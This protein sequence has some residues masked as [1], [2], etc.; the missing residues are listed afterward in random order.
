MVSTQIYLQGQLFAGEEN[1]YIPSGFLNQLKLWI[2][3][4]ACSWWQWKA[5]LHVV[6]QEEKGKIMAR[7]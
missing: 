7:H 3:I 5:I 1:G 2:D 4:A 6:W